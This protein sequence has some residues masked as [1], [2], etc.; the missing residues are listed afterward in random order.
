SK[1]EN[2]FIYKLLINQYYI[3]HFYEE[4]LVKPYRELSTVF[5]KQVDQ[6]VVDATVDGIANVIYATGENTREMQSGNLSTMLKWMVAGL[7]A[8]L[9]L[10]VVFGLATR[11]SDEIMTILS[12]LG[13]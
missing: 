11:H 1:M 3:P 4:Y 9:S 8:L 5:W 10:A 6:K 7:V 13:V 12:G 2:S